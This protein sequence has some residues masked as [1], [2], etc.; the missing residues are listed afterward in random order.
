M[1][2]ELAF[3][4]TSLILMFYRN[5]MT[6]DAK[7]SALKLAYL[8]AG[9]SFFFI[10]WALL[11]NDYFTYYQK[12]FISVISGLWAT[13]CYYLLGKLFKGTVEALKSKIV[14]LNRFIFMSVP[15]MVKNKKD[16]A[17]RLPNIIEELNK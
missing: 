8:I 14:M 10:A 17:K 3:L 5:Y 9:V 6:E 1:G 7:E 2:M 12:I 4:S 16:Y 15:S 13:Y 11:P